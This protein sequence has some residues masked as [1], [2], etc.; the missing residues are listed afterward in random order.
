MECGDSYGNRVQYNTLEWN[1][2]G[3]GKRVRV[4]VKL[5]MAGIEM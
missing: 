5:D 4:T 3:G 2:L 1:G